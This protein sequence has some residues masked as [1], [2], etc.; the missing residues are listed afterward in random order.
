MAGIGLDAE[1]DSKVL[2]F[3]TKCREGEAQTLS[4]V[5]QGKK[6]TYRG[7]ADMRSLLESRGENTLYANVRINGEVLN[8]RDFENIPIAEGDEIDILYFMGGGI[9]QPD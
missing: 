8:R 6:V 5:V 3:E 4:L 9:V 7:P 1:K 2:S